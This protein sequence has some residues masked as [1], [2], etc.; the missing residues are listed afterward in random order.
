MNLFSGT[1]FKNKDLVL[2]YYYL[3]NQIDRA[4]LVAGLGRTRTNTYY[5]VGR[6]VSYWLKKGVLKFKKIKDTDELG[7]R[8]IHNEETK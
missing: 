3:T 6:A 7:G 5:Y 8:D 4:E 2:I 1:N